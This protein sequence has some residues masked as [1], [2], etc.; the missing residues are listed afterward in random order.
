MLNIMEK[1]IFGF[2]AG[3]FAGA[4]AYHWI[5]ELVSNYRSYRIHRHMQQQQRDAPPWESQLGLPPDWYDPKQKK[6][7]KEKMNE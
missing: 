4:I 2:V 5:L 1:I 7:Q 3:L 6:Q